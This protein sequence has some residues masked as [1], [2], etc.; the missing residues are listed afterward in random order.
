MSSDHRATKCLQAAVQ[1]ARTP[2][3]A[4]ATQHHGNMFAFGTVPYPLQETADVR[5]RVFLRCV[6]E[7]PRAVDDEAGGLS[8]CEGVGGSDGHVTSVHAYTLGARASARF[9]FVKKEKLHARIY[10]IRYSAP[11]G[12]ICDH[13]RDCR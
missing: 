5:V 9:G 6:G 4:I 8:E 1:P 2:M 12:P 3:I 11:Y 13:H 7:H 10:D